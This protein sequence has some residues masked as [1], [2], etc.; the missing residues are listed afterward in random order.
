MGVT[1]TERTKIPTFDPEYIRNISETVYRARLEAAC[2]GD[3]AKM[4]EKDEDDGQKLR[5][6]A[7]QYDPLTRA[8]LDALGFKPAATGAQIT[9]GDGP[10]DAETV[11]RIPLNDGT[12]YGS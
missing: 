2:A 7:G 3:V 12:S 5:N 9:S 11:V 10:Q 4:I 6:R 8:Y 1:M